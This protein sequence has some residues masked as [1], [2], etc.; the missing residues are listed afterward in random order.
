MRL[1]QEPAT[2][3]RVDAPLLV[4][5]AERK[6]CVAHR[7][8][9][10][11]EKHVVAAVE[12]ERVARPRVARVTD[13]REHRAV[14]DWRV[15][16]R[17]V[18]DREDDTFGREAPPV[19]Q[20]E[21]QVVSGLR[22]GDHLA[23]D[24]QQRQRRRAPGVV[25]RLRE[26]LAVLP[27]RNERPAGQRPLA[28][29]D[30]AEEAVG[31]VLERAHAARGD[32]ERVTR[33]LRP[34][35]DAADASLDALDEV[36]AVEPGRGGAQQMDRDHGPAEPRTDDRDRAPA[37]VDLRLDARRTMRDSEAIV[38]VTC[39]VCGQPNE[40]GRKF[41][42]ECGSP[43]ALACS[44]CGSANAPGTKFCGECGS[45][46]GD[47]D[48]SAARSAPPASVAERRLVSVLFADLVG[49]TSA[50]EARD[51]E[52]TRELLTRYFDSS[53][54]IVE[55]YG[56]VVEKFIGDAV[57]AVWGAP[58]ANEDDA[59]R[60]VRAALELVAAVPAL[61]PALQARAGVLTGEAAVTLG[62]QGQGMVA[63]DL[64]NTASRIQSA[65]EPGMVLVG[66]ATRRAAEAAVAFEDAGTFEL[67]GKGEPV[68]LWR[69]LRVVAAR[70]GEGRSAG[71]EAAF[72]G[73]DRE[74]RLL[75]DVFH[76]TAEEGHSHLLSVVGVAGIGKS[77][78][79]WE[80]EKYVD[81][82]V[83]EAWWHR[84]RCL[85]YGEGV[86][87]WALAEMIRMRARITDDEP[88]D[89]ALGQARQGPRG[90]RPRPRG[91]GVRGAARAAPAW[92]GRS[93]RALIARTSSP[94]GACSSS[95][96]PS[97]TR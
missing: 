41:C 54:Q 62:A 60:A 33:R 40:A 39:G 35:R 67:K 69:A 94:A 6:R 52:D 4:G 27:A 25:E 71:L 96:W 46:L 53:R 1:G 16:R 86:A 76:A 43:L 90:D 2:R 51:A 72:V 5:V 13:A 73:R 97:S 18:P 64:V 68:S 24:P 22:D 63:G 37:H 74:L 58:V 49:F 59:E 65:A 88:A 80:F 8:P 42:G 48:V 21:D 93:G 79:A 45:P 32:V 92:S 61:D 56:G 91:Q 34:V 95:G 82:L 15:G 9:G 89:S 30:E 11:D 3:D 26:V 83:D 50:S 10:A 38:D 12:L 66:E 28:A 57:M 55:R 17:V 7:Q 87:Y 19:R 77:R 29:A 84:G 81:G 20:P 70:G 47:A 85:S 75:K 44:A 78:L 14:A 31:V 36:Q 23:C